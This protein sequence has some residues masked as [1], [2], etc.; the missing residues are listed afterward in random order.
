MSERTSGVPPVIIF[1]T[2][3]FPFKSCEHLKQVNLFWKPL[4]FWI[5]AGSPDPGFMTYSLIRCCFA[6]RLMAKME[7]ASKLFHQSSF[8]NPQLYNGRSPSQISRCLDWDI[9]I[10]SLIWAIQIKS[11]PI[12]A[13]AILL[14]NFRLFWTMLSLSLRIMLYSFLPSWD[15]LNAFHQIA[16]N[17]LWSISGNL[18]HLQK[19]Q[20]GGKWLQKHFTRGLFFILPKKKKKC[21]FNILKSL[22]YYRAKCY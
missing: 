14:G 5:K 3:Y 11:S 19:A 13:L 12:G 4:S 6:K 22:K 21:F 1:G 9:F 2:G 15:L 10:N 16:K 7:S 8:Q 18:S 17:I 20:N